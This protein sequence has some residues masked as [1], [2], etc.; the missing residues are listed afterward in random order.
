MEIISTSIPDVKLIVPRRHGDARGF[1]SEVY[2]R[3]VFRQAGLDLDFCQD[4]H[5]RSAQVGTLRGLHFQSPPFAQTKLVRVTKGAVLDVAIDIRHGSPWFGQHV[6]AEISE[7]N[8]T[9][10][11]VPRGFAHG[12]VTLRPDT[13]VVYKVDN[14]YAP[15]NDHGVIWDDPD[16]AI[17]WPVTAEQVM[18]SDKDKRQP[19]FR[20]LPAYFTY[21]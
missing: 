5:S 3:Q 12:F 6:A 11:L 21:S 2:N 10:I 19:K 13:E 8:W 14:Y 1:F 17:A 9:Q 4:N 20:D 7:E 18:L 15:A 16:L